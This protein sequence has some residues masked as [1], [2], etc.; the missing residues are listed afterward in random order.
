M[1]DYE[2]LTQSFRHHQLSQFIGANGLRSSTRRYA[3]RS[4]TCS[5]FFTAKDAK[6]SAEESDGLSKM[7]ISYVK[8][9]EQ[10]VANFQDRPTAP[11]H[12]GSGALLAQD[13][14]TN[15][16][17]EFQSFTD[18]LDTFYLP[19]IPTPGNTAFTFDFSNQDENLFSIA[20]QPATQLSNSVDP[21]SYAEDTVHS[22]DA[23]EG[24][25][26]TD[27]SVREA[28]SF[29]QT[30]F[31]IIHPRYPFLD[32]E[33]CSTAYLKWKTGE[34]ETCNDKDWSMCL[35]KLVCG[36]PPLMPETH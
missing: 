14:Q 11:V 26:M 29:F 5:K 23:S 18:P 17:A 12:T 1:S 15:A 24:S 9:L 10:Q 25:T 30:Y 27:V 20:Q 19:Q 28:A 4:K 33:E 21:G 31:E 2:S 8:D 16:Y 36:Q 32:V 22:L 6:T 7:Q 3:T 35:L 34:I 13:T